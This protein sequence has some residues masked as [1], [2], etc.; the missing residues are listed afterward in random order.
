MKL[1]KKTVAEAS[2]KDVMKVHVLL[3]R[4]V[5]TFTFTGVNCRGRNPSLVTEVV[6]QLLESD[7]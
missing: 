5:V 1:V 4:Q 2:G 7:D 3:K 6:T